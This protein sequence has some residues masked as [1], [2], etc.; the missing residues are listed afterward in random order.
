[1]SKIKKFDMSKKMSVFE[2]VPSGKYRS[3]VIDS[4]NKKTSSDGE[5][6]VLKWEVVKGN[7]KGRLFW[8]NLNIVNDS[9]VAVDMA[10]AEL[11]SIHSAFGLKKQI[12]D[13]KELHKLV[14]DVELKIIPE[15]D[16]Y[17]AKNQPISYESIGGSGS[18]DN[19]GKPEWDK[20]KKGKKKKGN[21][22]KKK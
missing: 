9:D 19:S 20:E 6:L 2:P 14:C 15:K 11:S 18:S 17:K 12:K 10:Y 1:M 7:H 3:K 16:G 4:E 8:T 21:G 5:M 13:S 22:K